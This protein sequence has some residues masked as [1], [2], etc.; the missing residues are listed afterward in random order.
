MKE[1]KQPA[2]PYYTAKEIIEILEKARDLGVRELKIEG[3]EASWEPTKSTL[4]TARP[5]QTRSGVAPVPQRPKELCKEHG[6]EM[7][8]GNWGPYCVE[9]YKARKN[10]GR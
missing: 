2:R 9:C 3:F 6:I 4:S 1:L 10:N 7:K 8:D 5:Q